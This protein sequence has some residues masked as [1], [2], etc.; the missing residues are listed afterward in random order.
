MSGQALVWQADKRYPLSAVR[1][2]LLP[3]LSPYALP[4]QNDRMAEI[5]NLRRVK[6]AREKAEAEAQAA[7]KHAKYGRT[8]DEQTSAEAEKRVRDRKL[9]GLRIEP[10][11]SADQADEP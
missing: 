2:T 11:G 9:D 3:V 1:L 6:K 4:W 10:E 8:T 7:A 5:V